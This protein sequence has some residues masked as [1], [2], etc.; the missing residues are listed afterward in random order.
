MHE[1]DF[2]LQK[3]KSKDY[4]FLFIVVFFT[5][6][7]LDNA[8]GYFSYD[9]ANYK[10]YLTLLSRYTFEDLIYFLIPQLPIPYVF[11]P[12]TG[13]FEFGFAST[14]LGLLTITNDPTMTYAIIGTLS[15]G[16]R[17]WILRK[18]NVHW[19]WIILLNI[20]SITLFEANAIRLGC[21]FTLFLLG[22]GLLLSK[23]SLYLAF[24]VFALAML[25]HLQIGFQILFFCVPFLGYKFIFETS[26][27][28]VISAVVLL[29]IGLSSIVLISG[30]GVDKLADY[31]EMA[32]FAGGIN[33]VSSISMIIWISTII[34]LSMLTR[35]EFSLIIQ[36][37]TNRAWISALLSGIPSLVLLVLVTNMG[38][39]S[40]RL[41][42]ISLMTFCS[43]S[44]MV[45]WKKMFRTYQKIFLI[46]LIS[47]ATINV[48]Y[49]YPLSNFFAPLVP[50]KPIDPLMSFERK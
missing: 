32:S 21:A 14:A 37:I 46:A 19:F 3:L 13:M 16:F 35:Q 5:Y 20:Y 36:S 43:F 7:S 30:F 39:V 15:I 8:D 24:S 22:V 6:L 28:L 38:A 34:H 29:W 1:A 9:F 47:I 49:R 50:F 27:R 31:E 12:P 25:F 4:F 23:K 41:W 11:I 42:Q 18:L 17:C 44:F 2:Q 26:Q 45:D 10:T 48:V 33:F 40:D